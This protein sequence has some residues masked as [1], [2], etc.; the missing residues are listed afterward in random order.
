MSQMDHCSVEEAPKLLT[1]TEISVSGIKSQ[2]W[3][4]SLPGFLARKPF[5]ASAVE[6][7][8][9][10]TPAGERG[11]HPHGGWR[12]SQACPQQGQSHATPLLAGWSPG[13]G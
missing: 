10:R 4:Q 5:Q 1:N 2:R 8:T 13:P 9:L 7:K 3:P 6:G 11:S 12:G